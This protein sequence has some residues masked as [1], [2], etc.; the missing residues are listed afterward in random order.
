VKWLM[1]VAGLGL[2]AGALLAVR[3]TRPVE[4]TAE[5]SLHRVTLATGPTPGERAV[6][7]VLKS[8]PS[9]ASAWVDGT[10]AGETPLE[11]DVEADAAP[12]AVELELPDFA[13]ASMMT[14]LRKARVV[15]V[16]RLAP[17]V[18][19]APSSSFLARRV[20]PMKPTTPPPVPTAVATL[21]VTAQQRPRDAGLSGAD[22]AVPPN[23]SPRLTL[24]SPPQPAQR[25]TEK[26]AVRAPAPTRSGTTEQLAL[27]ASAPLER[28]EAQAATKAVAASAPPPA[29]PAAPPFAPGPPSPAPQASAPALSNDDD[30]EEAE[31]PVPL[32][33]NQ[34]PEYP[35]A[36]RSR[37]VEA[38]TT[39]R[40]MVDARG[41]V[42]SVTP[43]KGEEP[44]VSAAIAAV[45]A[46]RY[47]P[48]MLRGQPIT[49]RV[50][51]TLRFQL[52]D[53]SNFE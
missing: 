49:Y 46:W 1:A 14:E 40:V 52:A 39:L 50:V 53:R 33:T 3:H 51:V 30:L 23:V 41:A 29:P 20:A 43:L 36:A 35:E 31:P 9:G 16:Q 8:L 32:E 12:V 2:A 11:V 17:A 4:A 45:K 15:V 18:G 28:P 25:L 38:R 44:F 19:R 6:R 24:R 34:P 5:R 21:A 10:Y 37:A 27:A 47:Q 48:A 22:L 7:L 26:A 13:R 42:A